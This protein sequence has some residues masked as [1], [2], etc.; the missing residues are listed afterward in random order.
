MSVSFKKW[1]LKQVAVMASRKALIVGHHGEHVAIVVYAGIEVA[2][3]HHSLVTVA[4]FILVL[5]TLS[6][7]KDVRDDASK[8]REA[9]DELRQRL[10]ETADA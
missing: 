6:V 1:C 2:G 7:I 5:G 9:N 3:Y 4:G 10:Q 8:L